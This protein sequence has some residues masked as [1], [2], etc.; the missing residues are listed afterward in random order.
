M[1]AGTKPG[2]TVPI[3][4][5]RDKASKSLEGLLQKR[6]NIFVRVAADIIHVSARVNSALSL[7]MRFNPAI[8]K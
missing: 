3:R 8:R 2:T 6:R 1:V 5:I 4:V 7:M